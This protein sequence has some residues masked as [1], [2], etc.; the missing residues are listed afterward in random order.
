MPKSE[1]SDVASDESSSLSESTI[2]SVDQRPVDGALS[3]PS[4]PNPSSESTRARY[5]LM[6]KLGEGGMGEVWDAEQTKPVRRQVAIKVI[7]RG[8]DTDS[9]VAR[10]E[11]ERQALAMMDHPGIAKVYDAGATEHGRPFFAMELVKGENILAYCERHRLTLR[12]RLELFCR[13]CEAI[14]H[15]HQKAIIHRDLKPSN[16]LVTEQSGQR[17]PKIIDFGVAKATTQS[18]TEQT[19]YTQI[20]QVIGTPAYMS[21]EQAE[22]SIADIDTRTDVYSLGVILYVLLCGRLPFD[23]KRLRSVSVDEMR[24]IVR[25]EDP[26]TP[27]AQAGGDIDGA[28]AT[29]SRGDLEG[30]L[31]WIAMKA[32]EKDRSRRYGSAQELADD[33]RRHL[34]HEPV[35]ARPVSSAY[36]IKKFV[37]RHRAGVAIAS[38]L[39]VS[40]A[41]SG[42][43][44]TY[45]ARQIADQRDRANEQ[46]ALAEQVSDFLINLFLNSDP[47]TSKGQDI[48]AREL[49][50]RGAARIDSELSDQPVVRARLKSTI[51]T[52]YESVGLFSD[53]EALLREALEQQRLLIGPDHLDSLDTQA[54]LTMALYRQGRFE[55]Q[56]PL[57]LDLL[58]RRQRVLGPDHPLTLESLAGVGTL[59]LEQG[60]IAEGENYFRRQLDGLQ[61][62]LGPDSAEAQD[63]LYNLAMIAYSQGRIEDAVA[64]LTVVLASQRR[65]L[66]DDDRSTITTKSTLGVF[67]AL[68]GNPDLA[69]PMLKQALASRIQMLGPEHDG[70]LM[71]VAYLA[72]LNRESGRLE[73]ALA[74]NSD[75]LR[76]RL[77][78][79]GIEHPRTKLALADVGRVLSAM[80]CYDVAGDL[81]AASLPAMTSSLGADHTWTLGTRIA[82]ADARV[83][84]GD[85]I[86][87]L[88]LVE[89]AVT[90]ARRADGD[91]RLLGRALQVQGRA[92]MGLGRYDDSLIALNEAAETFDGLLRPAHPLIA[93]ARGHYGVALSATGDFDAAESSLRT[94]FEQLSQTTGGNQ[95]GVREAALRLADHY[96]AAGDP[97]TS[98]RWR[99][100]ADTAAPARPMCPPIAA[101][102]GRDLLVAWN[103]AQAQPTSRIESDPN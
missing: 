37:R 28:G 29:Y 100:R 48:T 2:I 49:L 79:S 83:R 66:G 93:E 22:M 86:R 15:A 30:D 63:A 97:D 23:P 56:E 89:P 62:S 103:Q 91:K 75:L 65:T 9:V 35:L 58:A 38:L 76:T 25:E 40:L 43:V 68:N 46:A 71:S 39:V 87:G 72:N 80:G 42:A 73:P 64:D 88:E 8:M 50:D 99:T 85:Y 7:K 12:E 102:N 18:L 4:A 82:W 94:S 59:R 45:Q 90:S 34:R 60:R 96:A 41:T 13:V 70:T 33:V 26:P 31:D 24:R 55:E 54:A 95:Q 51:G 77:R 69:E 78:V 27:S 81:L 44:S 52:V 74:Q 47:N 14:Q 57:E 1:Y 98:T 21:P 10:F 17:Q 5:R 101:G 32:L 19:L 11:A 20:G 36:R 67:H 92:L 6:R 16:V 84:A 53:S 3:N 61:Q